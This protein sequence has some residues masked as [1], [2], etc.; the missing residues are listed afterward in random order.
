MIIPSC[1]FPG[2]KVQKANQ[3]HII[4][5]QFLLSFSSLIIIIT[6]KAC[7]YITAII[8][9]PLKLPFLPLGDAIN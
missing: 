2:Q 7:N 9:L 1:K 3:K 8:F 4:A 6:K 5:T